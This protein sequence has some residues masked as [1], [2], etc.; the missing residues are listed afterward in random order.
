MR[1]SCPRMSIPRRFDLPGSRRRFLGR[2]RYIRDVT[3]VFVAVED[4]NVV[5]VHL[6]SPGS[7]QWPATLVSGSEYNQS[8]GAL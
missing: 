2:L 4:V 5:V 7:P 3:L 1:L 6:G 8:T